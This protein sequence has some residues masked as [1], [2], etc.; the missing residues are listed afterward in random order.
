MRSPAVPVTSPLTDDERDL[1]AILGDAWNR[2]CRIVEDGPS[3]EGD[4]HEL[5]LHMNALQTRVMA[6]AAGRLYPYELRVLGG[7]M[8][9]PR[10]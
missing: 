3:R 5:G 7:A 6:Q 9:E 8:P 2:L 4:L 1:L 10:S